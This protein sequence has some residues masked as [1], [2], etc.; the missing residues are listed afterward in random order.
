MQMMLYNEFVKNERP[1]YVYQNQVFATVFIL[2]SSILFSK[3][4]KKLIYFMV[5][6]ISLNIFRTKRNH[7]IETIDSLLVMCFYVKFSI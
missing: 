3:T 4:E 2:I 5:I 7:E 6:F 1:I